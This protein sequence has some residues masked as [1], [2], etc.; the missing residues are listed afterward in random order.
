MARRL[1]VILLLLAI[2]GAAAWT[3]FRWNSPTTRKTDP[4]KALPAQ[5]AVIIELPAPLTTWE[6]WTH[7]AQLWD[8]VALTPGARS[9]D[10]LL[11]RIAA[12]AET[13]P[14]L[15]ERLNQGNLLVALVGNGQNLGTIAIWPLHRDTPGLEQLGV[16]LGVDLGK[17]SAA[18]SGGSIELKGDTA[19]AGCQ[20]AWKD[21]LALLGS[22]TNVVDEALLAM[23]GDGLR[24]DSTFVTAQRTLGSGTDGHMLVHL[25]RAH[26]ILGHW[27]TN[28]AVE[29]LRWPE[30]WLAMD[31]RIRPEAALLSGL[32]FPSRS[33]TL[34]QALSAQGLSRNGVTRVLPAT[35]TTCITHQVSDPQRYLEELGVHNDSL[36]AAGFLWCRGV[37]ALA[38]SP[39]TSGAGQRDWAVFQT[40]DPLAPFEALSRLCPTGGC[41]TANHRGI[42]LLRAPLAGMLGQLLGPTFDRFERPWYAVL[43]DKAICSDQREA[44]HEAIDAFLDGRTLAADERNADFL[45]Q[46]AT[47]AALTVW[48]DAGRS[49]TW[50]RPHLR[51]DAGPALN[52]DLLRGLGRFLMQVAPA[53]NGAF[54]IT[55]CLQHGAAVKQEVGVLWTSAIGRPLVRGPF[56]VRNHVNRTQEVLVQDDANV[57]HL[58]SSTGSVLWKRELDGPIMGEVRQVDKF[59]NGKLQ[60]L[61]NTE[62][63][64]H[65]ID[66]NGKDVGGF[67]VSLPEKASAPLSV[68]DY[69]GTR[70]YRVLVPTVNSTLLNYDLNGK[71]V[72]GWVPPRTPATC[73]VPVQHLRVR[74]K[75]H[76][77]LV[78][79][80]G[81][82]TVL[83]RKAAPRFNALVN[84]PAGATPIGLRAALDIAGCA[85]LWTDSAGQTFSGTFDG[86]RTGPYTDPLTDATPGLFL[87]PR[88]STIG[89]AT[90][91]TVTRDI[92]LDGTPESITANGDGRVVVQRAQP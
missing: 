72:Q 13:Q 32:I 56:I 34:M 89:S 27:L 82:V 52:G 91:I 17:G 6:R 4:W 55:L 58:L 83:D 19:W 74:G 21:G 51:A 14:A 24:S 1:P 65:L 54:P 2:L 43:G 66:R 68:F 42:R 45:Q 78:D 61:F 85:V 44:L 28:D 77:V 39:D 35:V 15:L 30:G 25:D 67:P 73:A 92:N 80:S 16:A 62:G 88:N 53:Q 8:A 37:F 22:N 57:I 48:A 87:F 64:I 71:P 40:D 86:K 36:A 46:Y 49:D 38:S 41:D 69:D 59:R 75:D 90:P 7:T 3:L 81:N 63:R 5:S 23:G 60:L 18:W 26:R 31:V 11:K 33:D 79:H 10:A 9:L 29:G 76:L 50:L 70:E 47:D 20:F 12:L 84:V